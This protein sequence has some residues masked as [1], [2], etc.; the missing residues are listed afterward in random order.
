MG[1]SDDDQLVEKE[2]PGFGCFAWVGTVVTIRVLL[3]VV[4]Q[5]GEAGHEEMPPS[6]TGGEVSRNSLLDVASTHFSASCAFPGAIASGV[7]WE[8][9]S[10]LQRF[11]GDFSSL[12][13]HLVSLAE[14]SPSAR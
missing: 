2:E 4:G 1:S 11:T 13:S 12:C 3:E 6:T 14:S 7:S 8:S 10:P 5:T 9:W